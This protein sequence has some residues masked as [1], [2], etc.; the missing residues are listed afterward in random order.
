MTNSLP[1]L[2]RVTSLY[3]D[4]EDRFRV[5]GEVTPEDTRCLWLTQ[6]LLVRLVPLLLDWLGD[7]ARAEGKDDL[8]QAELMQD[9]AQQAAKARLEPQTA[10]PVPSMP[11]PNAP[12][13]TSIQG[14]GA[15]S[16]R[17]DDLWLVKE[18]DITKSTNGVLTLTFKRESGGVQL[19]MAPVELRQ[20]LIILHSQWLQAGWPVALW[21]EWIDTTPEKGEQP[22][23]G[24]H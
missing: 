22:P 7:I 1:K 24:L 15:H 14:E 19:G 11:A 8:G 6:R 4:T 21:P 10:V 16:Q 12:I 5:T 17:P 13:E 2:Q 3:S 23:T 9:F 20:W 18:V